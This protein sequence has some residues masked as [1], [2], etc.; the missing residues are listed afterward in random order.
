M[1]QQVSTGE[2]LLRL[3]ASLLVIGSLLGLLR[4]GFGH[5]VGLGVT[6]AR[7]GGGSPGESSADRDRG[8]AADSTSIR[9]T[10]SVSSSPAE[11]SSANSV[12]TATKSAPRGRFGGRRA[13]R[14]L[15]VVDRQALS[16]TTSMAV[17][18]VGRRAYLVG[19]TEASLSLL[20]DVSDELDPP[21][22]PAPVAAPAAMT[23]AVGVP[24]APVV[25][26][27]DVPS[28]ALAGLAAPALPVT[29]RDND[30]GAQRAALEA[31]LRQWTGAPA[32]RNGLHPSGM[33]LVET[34]FQRFGLPG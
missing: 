24:T 9:R 13:P 3:L 4:R 5:L 20:A 15:E 7:V 16:R 17:V 6:F 11:A 29:G 26:G 2:L 21:V 18:R 10:G 28:L 30:E 34:V 1:A 19:A 33:E 22:L 32:G 27:V 14:A 23:P 12:V 8:R 25:A 31:S